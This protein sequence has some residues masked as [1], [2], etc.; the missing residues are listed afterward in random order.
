MNREVIKR[1]VKDLRGLLDEVQTLS[2][3]IHEDM[4]HDAVVFNFGRFFKFFAFDDITFG[5]PKG[6]DAAG[7]SRGKAVS[8]EFEVWSKNFEEHLQK[9]H[10]KKE[11]SDVLIFCWKDDWPQCPSNFDVLALEWFWTE[12]IENLVV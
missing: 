4:Y 7:W 3:P 8:I 1:Y 9:G 11:D 12:E 2:R 6:L 5:S 10:V